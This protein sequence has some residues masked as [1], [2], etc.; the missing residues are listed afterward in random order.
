MLVSFPSE[1]RTLVENV[2]WET[3]VALA[4]DRRSCVPRITY[5]R[6]L[7]ELMSPKKVHEMVKTLLGRLVAAYAEVCEIEILSVAS[8]TFRRQDLKRGFEA[9][10]AFYVEHAEAMRAKDEIDLSIDP[11][12]ELVI[13]VEITASAIRKLDLFAKLGVAEVWRHDGEQLRAYHLVGDSYQQ[14]EQSIVL[15]GF[16]LAQA[17]AIVQQR[18]KQGEVALVRDFRNSIRSS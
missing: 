9:D 14:V 3:Y 18:N 16:P 11:P 1:T 8:T 5:D 7:M 6:G 15:D 10:E 13:E 12:P 2:R 17:Q 4:D